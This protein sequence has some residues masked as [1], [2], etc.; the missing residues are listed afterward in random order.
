MVIDVGVI[1]NAV[2]VMMTAEGIN[3][4]SCSQGTVRVL[5]F[6]RTSVGPVTMD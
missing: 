6:K 2:A 5:M 4:K 3:C 1:M